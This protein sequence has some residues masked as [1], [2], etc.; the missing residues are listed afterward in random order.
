MPAIDNG[1]DPYTQMELCVFHY[2]A[3]LIVDIMRRKEE[4]TYALVLR[5]QWLLHVEEGMDAALEATTCVDEPSG[6]P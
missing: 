5:K 4:S 6:A 1:L 2:D 3:A